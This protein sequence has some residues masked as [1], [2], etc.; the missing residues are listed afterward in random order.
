M[1]DYTHYISFVLSKAGIES[2]IVGIF[3][4]DLMIE[5]G[6]QQGFRKCRYILFLLLLLGLAGCGG[7]ENIEDAQHYNPVSPLPLR[8]IDT[9]PV[10]TASPSSATQNVSNENQGSAQNTPTPSPP[11]TAQL[12][13]TPTPPSNREPDKDGKPTKP[14]HTPTPIPTPVKAKQ[15]LLPDSKK[16]TP[17]PTSTPVAPV[18]GPTKTS[19]AA[20]DEKD[21]EDL[22]K[23]KN[24]SEKKSGKQSTS[25]QEIEDPEFPLTSHGITIDDMM[26]CSNISNRKPFNCSD[27]F[28][29]SE[30]SRIYTW[31]KVSKVNS[32]K[33]IK[34]V[35]YW[36]GTVIATVKLKLKYTSMRTWSQKTFNPLRAV[37]EWK[38]VVMTEEDELITVKKFTVVR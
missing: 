20:E 21:D 27:T 17:T 38:I 28:S 8:V 26:V 34:H 4:V 22:L 11:D 23:P 9:T 18:P 19:K 24:T 32:P 16:A 36:K 6:Y 25:E 37:G 12:T 14:A 3:R 29:L 7:D 5:L 31:M 15:T 30:V 2:L 35:Y 1:K 13:G 10:P 33:I